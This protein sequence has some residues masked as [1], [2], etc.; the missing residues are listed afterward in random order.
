MFFGTTAIHV[1]D[2]ADKEAESA[3]IATLSRAGLASDVDIA[4]GFGVHRKA[5]TA[6]PWDGMCHRERPAPDPRL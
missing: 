2:V 5:F 1:Y 6:T 4:A 3:C